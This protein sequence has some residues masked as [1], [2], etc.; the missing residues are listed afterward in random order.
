MKHSDIEFSQIP[1]KNGEMGMITLQR[2][3]ALNALTI[4]MCRSID[5]H[6]VQWQNDEA[7]KAVIIQGDGERAFCAGG[8]V[9][10]VYE[11]GRSDPERVMDFFRQ[12]YQMN[13]RLFHFSKPYIAL[14][15]GIT[16]GGGLG[17]SVHG[18]HRVGAE[19]LQLAMPETGIGFYPDI[20]GSHFLPRC[21]GKLGWYLGLSGDKVN[22]YDAFYLGLIDFVIDRG[23]FANVIDQL[24]NL[25][26][27]H[28][29][30]TQVSELLKGW[31]LPMQQS[32]LL[33]DHAEIDQ[34]FTASS[35]EEILQKLT[36]TPSERS[37]NILQLLKQKSPTSL[38]ITLKLFNQAALQ[39]FDTCMDFELKL[40]QRFLQHPDFSEGV[41]AAIIDKDRKPQWQPAN[42]NEVDDDLLSQWGI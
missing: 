34:A 5:E 11:L 21:P 12:E 20:G 38:K 30:H 4:A 41:R 9:R 23:D 19:S 37:E 25:N 2:S 26:F 40:T 28:D 22:A 14:M 31:Q 24:T 16:M 6:L 15:H 8:D 3:Q 33:T 18:S 1:V 39:D 35:V 36:E 27:D 32:P 7:I 10:M 42:L 13:R 17:V 29:A